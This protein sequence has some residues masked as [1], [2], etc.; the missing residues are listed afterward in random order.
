MGRA[1]GYELASIRG[2]PP[3][4]FIAAAA[5]DLVVME[6]IEEKMLAGTSRMT[7]EGRPSTGQDMIKGRRTEIEFIN[8]LVA[9]KSNAVGVS[10]PT[11]A[12]LTAA[13]QR[14]ERGE[15][16]SSPDNVAGL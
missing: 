16:D 11:H 6:E 5:G 14:V 10:A 15:L 8:G 1:L 3:E 7:E 12:A 13:V 4:K 9:A 2:L